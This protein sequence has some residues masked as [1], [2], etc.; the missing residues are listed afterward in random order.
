MDIE[1]GMSQKFEAIRDHPLGFLAPS[2]RLVAMKRA[3][4]RRP[5][6]PSAADHERLV[7]LAAASAAFPR[8]AARAQII[9]AFAAGES[10]ESIARK[11]GLTARTV[12]KWRRRYRE[13]GLAGLMD[14]PRSGAPRRLGID[15]SLWVLVL[16]VFTSPLDA[17][18]WTTRSLARATGMSQSAI[19]RIWRALGVGCAHRPTSDAP[20][21][22]SDPVSLKTLV[23]LHV[24]RARGARVT[25]VDARRVRRVDE[26][27]AVGGDTD[28]HLVL[29]NWRPEDL[30]GM[31]AQLAGRAG[32]HLHLAPRE[33][34][35]LEILER[36]FA[37]PGGPMHGRLNGGQ[38]H[39]LE[40]WIRSRLG[41]DSPSPPELPYRW[42]PL[43]MEVGVLFEREDPPRR[44]EGLG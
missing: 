7:R 29:C 40:R 18:R 4:A 11:H 5:L 22:L 9:L 15:A 32:I 25:V 34:G 19:S 26:A 10:K 28:L 8:A 27:R 21:G 30:P 44:R 42:S 12:G 17:D 23:E 39:P 6:E 38:P 43:A 37:P 14:R 24:D 13:M 1:P 31:V 20:S 41:L 2:I 16:T 3:R 35:W 33:D 36:W